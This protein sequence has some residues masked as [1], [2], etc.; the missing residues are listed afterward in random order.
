MRNFIRLVAA[1][2]LLAG[3]GGAAVLLAAGPA[4]ATAC[5]SAVTAGN[6]CTLTGTLTVTGGSLTLTSPS[7]LAWSTTLTGLDQQLVDTTAGHTSYLVN[8]ATGSGAG[9]HVTVSATQFTTGTYTLANSGT[10]STTGSTSSISATTAPT[11]ACSSGATCTLPS[12]TTT[13]PVAITTAAS[14]PTAV[15]IYDTALS[16][17]LGSITIGSSGNPVGW[18]VV[19]PASTRAGTYT[20]TFTLEIISGP[21]ADCQIGRNAAHA[22]LPPWQ[23]RCWLP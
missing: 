9:W 11:A 7:A 14:S 21:L 10:L 16:T 5:G 15:T 13:Y 12:D 4:E 18:W 17:G 6:S 23:P 8:D 19:V 22:R 1:C 20:S 2:A 3:G